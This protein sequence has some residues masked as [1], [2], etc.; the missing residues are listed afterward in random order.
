MLR[1]ASL[2]LVVLALALAACG[3]EKQGPTA[4]DFDELM[5]KL[6][7]AN[8]DAAGELAEQIG[9]LAQEDPAVLDRLVE[10]LRNEEPNVGMLTFEFALADPESLPDEEARSKAR[11][12]ALEVM[13]YRLTL[14]GHP[15][16][17]MDSRKAKGVLHLLMQKPD[18]PEG[19]TGE[20]RAAFLERY[21]RLVIQHMTAPGRV[22]LLLVA[23]RPAEGQEPA[24]LWTASA[25]GYDAFVAERAK[26]MDEALAAGLTYTPRE[27]GFVLCLVPPAPGT[28]DRGHVVAL[29]APNRSDHFDRRDL[30][31]RPI[32][33]PDSGEL[34]VEVRVAPERRE[35]LKAWS[36]K[37]KGRDMVLVVN[38]TAG[39]PMRIE[40]PID[41]AIGI[42]FGRSDDP[43]AV[44][45]RDDLLRIVSTVEIPEP[46]TGRRVTEVPPTAVTPAA[47]ALIASG[48]AGAQR[49]GE[50][51]AEGGNIGARAARILE[52][53]ARRRTSG[54]DKFVPGNN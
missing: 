34:G 9:A 52:L 48:N 8:E 38:G 35:A 21:A 46:M 49:M 15:P 20:E 28:S 14:F 43:R 37:H 45:L 2:I 19:V 42:P 44:A 24:S 16:G 32:T 23:P 54:G 26:A 29:R 12:Q 5:T 6:A 53:I 27:P 40:E 39:R 10:T 18:S 13:A 11:R 25:D 41:G 36:E 51:R 50:L 3:N 7:Y 31:F 47:A 1:H 17:V 30:S 22:E 4:D 33:F